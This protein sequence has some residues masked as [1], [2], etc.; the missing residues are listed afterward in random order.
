MKV[1]NALFLNTQYRTKTATMRTP[2]LTI[3]ILFLALIANGQSTGGS[4]DSEGHA[5]VG[6][7]EWDDEGNATSGSND[8]RAEVELGGWESSEYLII[9]DFGFSV[10]NSHNVDGIEVNVERKKEGGNIEDLSIRLTKDGENNF[11]GNAKD[12]GSWPNSDQTE[13]YGNSGD[14][15]GASFTPGEVNA[16]GFGVGI[17]A[18]NQSGASKKAYVDNVTIKVYHSAGALPIE[19]IHF[20]ATLERDNVKLV[21]ASASETNN[22]FYTIER[23]P[24]GLSFEPVGTVDGAGNSNSRIDYDYLDEKPL[25]GTSYYRLKQTDF[26]GEYEYFDVIAVDYRK[27]GKGECEL[28]VNPNPCVPQ[29][30]LSLGECRPEPG[31]PFRVNVF[32]ISGNRVSTDLNGRALK[33]GTSLH[34]NTRNNMAPGV[35]VVKASSGEEAHQEKVKVK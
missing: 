4:A 28:E 5:D 1:D 31:N 22:D 25:E 32:D 33:E 20:D 2:I 10:P 18:E 27:N 12:A 15:W 14:A 29:C 3:S 17:S 26:N 30:K 35:Y 23:S 34:L 8:N 24:N 21:W 13:T 9:T 6:N 19:L 16:S 11:V 7:Q